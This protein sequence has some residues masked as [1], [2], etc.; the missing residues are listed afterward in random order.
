MKHKDLKNAKKDLTIG[1]RIP[2][3]KVEG[4]TDKTLEIMIANYS[5]EIDF[6]IENV[7]KA[8]DE[9]A[10]LDRLKMFLQQEHKRREKPLLND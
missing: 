6:Q 8:F 5:I 10:K 2:K 3:Y 7:R 4:L 9:L 1:K